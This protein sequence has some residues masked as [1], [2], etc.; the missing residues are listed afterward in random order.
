MDKHRRVEDEILFSL[1]IKISLPRIC[2]VKNH[3]LI[4]RN[5]FT[6]TKTHPDILR[7]PWQPILRRNRPILTRT[8]ERR[9]PPLRIHPPFLEFITPLQ[10]P[11]RADN[12]LLRLSSPDL[13]TDERVTL[14]RPLQIKVKIHPDRSHSGG[15]PERK[16]RGDPLHEGGHLGKHTLDCQ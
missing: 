2:C 14:V 8:G 6:K 5:I 11:N 16:P 15:L 13:R 7:L 9:N 3:K 4:C 10:Q 12:I 1:R